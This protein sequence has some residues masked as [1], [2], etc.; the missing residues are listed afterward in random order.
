MDAGVYP[1]HIYCETASRVTTQRGGLLSLVGR[2]APGDQLFVTTL[3]R[4]GRNTFETFSLIRELREKKIEFYAL[5]MPQDQTSAFSTIIELLFLTFAE[6]ENVVRKERQMQGIQIAKAKG[7]YLGR[8]PKVTKELGDKIDRLL[9]KGV[10]KTEI[11]DYLKISRSTV[12][13]YLKNKK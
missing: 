13:S 2:L 6:M 5:N 10:K 3:D 12:Y 4:L 1:E 7:K 9:E 11:A 8:K